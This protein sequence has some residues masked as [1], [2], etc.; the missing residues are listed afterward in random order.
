MTHG[1]LANYVVWAAGEYGPGSGGAVL[2]SSLAFDL[3]VTS[4]V[5]PLVAGSVVVASAESGAEALA[6]LVGARGGFDVVKVVPGHLPLLAALISD[7][8][9]VSAARVLVVGGEALAGALVRDWLERA[10]GSVVVNEYGPTETVVG[11]CAFRVVAGQPVGEQ[12]P[13][14][15]PIA[16][17]RVFVLD[18]RLGLVPPGVAGELYIAGAGLA[19]GYAGRPGLTA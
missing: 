17:T 8:A 15:R 6:G 5:V 10:P 13:I 2:H 18:D 9:A 19:R 11:C 14:G 1:G 16:N 3:T 12:V 7:A 4:V